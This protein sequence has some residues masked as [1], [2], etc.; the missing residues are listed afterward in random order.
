MDTK[1]YQPPKLTTAESEQHRQ[2]VAH[3]NAVKEWGERLKKYA[4]DHFREYDSDR[5]LLTRLTTT[6]NNKRDE[7]AKLP[8]LL[9]ACWISGICVPENY[10]LHDALMDAIA[11]P[12]TNGHSGLVEKRIDLSLLYSMIDDRFKTSDPDT[13]VAPTR[14]NGKPGT[15]I[16]GCKLVTDRRALAHSAASADYTTDRQGM[17][18]RL[19][20]DHVSYGEIERPKLATWLGSDAGATMNAGEFLC[21][22]AVYH[23]HL[24]RDEI[25][26]RV[27]CSGSFISYVKRGQ[28]LPGPEL[29]AKFKPLMDSYNS[30]LYPRFEALVISNRLS[31]AKT[32]IDQEKKDPK[33]TQRAHYETDITNELNEIP[34]AYWVAMVMRHNHLRAKAPTLPANSPPEWVL[35]QQPLVTRGDYLRAVRLALGQQ[36]GDL[37]KLRLQTGELCAIEHY[38]NH[39]HE[40]IRTK[41]IAHYQKLD[42]ERME[43][44]EA[45]GKP[46]GEPLF[47]PKV[48]ERLPSS[49]R[50][51]YKK[52][53]THQARLADSAQDTG[54]ALGGG[55]G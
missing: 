24:S 16:I 52:K 53:E 30:A 4:Q 44:L 43:T 13:V 6:L 42:D 26:E 14:T 19:K 21:A 47:Q 40:R 35:A 50:G 51:P 10:E 46:A 28:A 34:Q 55:P 17:P 1:P 33:H 49:R 41:V 54:T 5:T 39:E 31:I 32:L 9:V 2:W 29:L 25:G 3:K 18:K 27:G 7:A 45:Q 37:A 23:G 38:G 48:Y 8:E 20:E 11:L 15:S 36:V 22:F 12:R